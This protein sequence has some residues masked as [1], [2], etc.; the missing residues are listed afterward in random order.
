MQFVTFAAPEMRSRIR[1][2]ACGLPQNM[3]RSPQLACRSPEMISG[4][5]FA[6]FAATQ[7]ALVATTRAILLLLLTLLLPHSAPAQCM[8]QW[9]PLDSSTASYP[10]TDLPVTA[11]IMW[12]ADGQGGQPPRLVIGG[13]FNV[14]G[15]VFAN[16]N[17]IYDPATGAWSALDASA[18][19]PRIIYSWAV[20][21]G[22]ELVAGGLFATAGGVTVNNIAR[23]TG[24]TWA[25]L[26]SGLPGG[27]VSELVVMPNGDLIAGGDFTAAAGAAANF[28]ARWDGTAWSPLGT[29]VDNQVRALAVMPN[30]DL[31]VGG[32]FINAGGRTA[33]RIARWD[34]ATWSTLGTGMNGSVMTL[35]VLPSGDLLAGGSFWTANDQP[36]N[37]IA[38]WNGTRWSPLGSGVGGASFPVIHSIAV[39]PGGDVI[40]GG[41][42]GTAGSTSANL[43]ARWNGTDWS[44]LGSGLSTLIPCSVDTLTVLPDGSVAVGGQFSTAGGRAMGN[45]ARWD[46]AAWTPVGSGMNGWLFSLATMSNGDL[47]AGGS[48]TDVG[49]VI[50]NN[51]ARWNGWAWS[52]LG[53]GV[54]SPNPA[55][56]FAT[57]VI[58][59]G[60]L[61]VG[62]RFQNAGALRV[63]NIARWN[64]STWFALDAGIAGEV[65]ELAAFSNGDIIAG[66][67]FPTAGLNTA[68]H[69]ARWD[70]ETWSMLGALAKADGTE[71][72]VSA[73]AVL[74]TGDVI[75]AGTFATV[76]GVAASGIARWNGSTWSS[77]GTGLGG[78]SP[79]VFGL[80]VLPSGDLIAAGAFTTADGVTVNNI[81]RWDG[82]T[83]WPL[84]AGLNSSA[85]ALTLLPGGDLV[86]LGRFPTANGTIVNR[87]ARWNGTSW[88]LEG[89][90]VYP[91]NTAVF[92]LA[93]LP[94]GDFVV[95]GLF[96]SIGG[97]ITPNI[98]RWGCV[99]TC[100][101]IDFNNNTVF[102]EDAD[103]IAFFDVLSGAVCSTCN[104]IDFNNNTVFPE[105]Q[106]VIDFFNVLAGGTCP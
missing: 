95:G 27:T 13:S 47:I 67:R 1:Q 55:T 72:S 63:N 7:G 6:T 54:S 20:L 91:S 90:G 58:P 56:V 3:A 28:I 96:V 60:D 99:R 30:G 21:P 23:W 68:N 73:L 106:D 45:I 76:Q 94:G 79:A 62:G 59:G 52:A 89:A 53:A 80:I 105:D 40:V 88:S 44:A 12:D 34:G 51:V 4:E 101:D 22:G 19:A 10:G 37:R 43:I 16:G 50:V 65:R 93:V 75:V 18:T 38:S 11:S 102:P 49:G 82:A 36:A 26:G 64:G 66:G 103:V 84:D 35:A 71:G 17:A 8:P 48:F 87:F 98:A 69:V 41:I 85:S 32:L 46:G 97:L 31:V 70:G 78:T 100:D 15:S 33:N 61:V 42:F 57:V 86:A 81:A 24:T 25:P 77:L 74:P 9:Q 104:D 2:I 14:A 39:L 5:G 92:S 83:W 29:G